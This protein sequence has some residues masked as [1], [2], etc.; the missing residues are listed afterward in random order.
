MSLILMSL[1]CDVVR[2]KNA[3]TLTERHWLKQVP[4]KGRKRKAQVISWLETHK[5]GELYWRLSTTLSFVCTLP[6]GLAV[7][8]AALNIFLSM[9]TSLGNALILIALHKVTS[10]VSMPGGY[11]SLR[12]SS[13]TTTLCYQ[14]IEHCHKDEMG[15]F[16]LLWGNTNRFRYNLVRSVDL[17][18]ARH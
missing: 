1:N 14:N 17:H 11:W 3:H 15:Y 10:V 4:C 6:E 7:F 18:I 13:Y 2:C 9:T 8:F 12:W 16:I 5:N